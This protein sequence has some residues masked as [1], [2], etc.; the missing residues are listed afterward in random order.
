MLVTDEKQYVNLSF[1][2]KVGSQCVTVT[3]LGLTM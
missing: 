1:F 2:L 3:S